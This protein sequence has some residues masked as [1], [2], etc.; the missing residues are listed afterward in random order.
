MKIDTWYVPELG[1]WCATY[2][3]DDG[4]P[5]GPGPAIGYATEQEAIDALVA[6]ANA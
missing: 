6:S 5:D 2:V 4:L 3:D 1:F